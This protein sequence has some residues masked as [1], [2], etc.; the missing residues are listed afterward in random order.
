MLNPAQKK[1]VKGWVRRLLDT[2]D[3]SSIIVANHLTDL[4]HEEDMTAELVLDALEE[5]ECEAMAM[6]IEL[7]TLA[8]V[9]E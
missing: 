5:L 3:V 6:R 1:V 7:T 4:S 9:K 2:G 8:K